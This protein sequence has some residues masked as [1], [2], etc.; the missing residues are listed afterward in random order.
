MR[1]LSKLAAVWVFLGFSSLTGYAYG[2][3]T[4]ESCAAGDIVNAVRG[5]QLCLAIKTAKGVQAP[6]AGAQLLILLHGD[7]SRGGPSDYHYR[8]AEEIVANHP[9]VIAIAVLRPGYFDSEG[10]RSDGNDNGR[11]DHYNAA[12]IDSMAAAIRTLRVTYR[13]SRIVL[14]GHSGGSAFSG[15]ILG[16]HPGT[17]DA[18]ILTSCP[19]DVPRWRNSGGGRPWKDSLSPSSYI[20]KVPQNARV[21]ALTGSKDANTAPSLGR[22]Y[23]E[24]LAKRGIAAEFL[25]VPGATHDMDSTLRTAVRQAVTTVLTAQTA[26]P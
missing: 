24:G 7:V 21:I 8:I 3:T 6:D 17:V 10:K 26:P 16:R 19:C 22:A 25:E 11:R 13:P 14:V 2:V 15:V 9:D 5:D 18:A 1:K 4:S 20:D 12:N 23:A